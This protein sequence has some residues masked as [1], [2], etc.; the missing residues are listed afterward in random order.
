MKTIL[1]SALLV[2]IGLTAR[3]VED[4]PE[5]RGPGAQGHA[6]AAKLPLVWDRTNNVTWRTAL[7]GRGLVL[8]GHR[9][10]PDLDDHRHRRRALVPRAVRGPRPREAAA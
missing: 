2:P 3:A 5:F 9:G 1:L 4:W 7:P 10:Q 6:D 8:A